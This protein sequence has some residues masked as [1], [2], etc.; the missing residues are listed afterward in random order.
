MG[1]LVD[2]FDSDAKVGDT[3]HVPHVSNLVANDKLTNSQVTLQAPTE[4]DSSISLDQYKESSFLVED[5]VA[6]QS[7]YD[8]SGYYGKKAGYAIA[9][10]IDGSLHGLYAGL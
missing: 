6:I 7:Q 1:N 3:I 9:K 4:T 10:A 5:K 8:L 2:R